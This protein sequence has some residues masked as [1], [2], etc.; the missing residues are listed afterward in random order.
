MLNFRMGI[1]VVAVRGAGKHIDVAFES[2][3]K[4]AL[5]VAGGGGQ[6]LP[7]VPA[8]AARGGRPD[9]VGDGDSIPSAVTT[10]SCLQGGIKLGGLVQMPAIWSRFPSESARQTQMRAS[11]KSGRSCTPS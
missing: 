3:P 7:S 10:E 11:G 9:Q 6:A 8:A 1:N 5:Q 2:R 4:V